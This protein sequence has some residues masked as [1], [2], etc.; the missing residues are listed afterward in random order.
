MVQQI[1][2]RSRF[3]ISVRR[4]RKESEVVDLVGEN[5]CDTRNQEYRNG[6]EDHREYDMEKFLQRTR[7]VKLCRFD[8]FRG[9]RRHFVGIHKYRRTK[10][11]EDVVY[12]HRCKTVI[13]R[14][15]ERKRRRGYKP[16][17][18]RKLK[19]YVVYKQSV[20]GNEY[21]TRN[22]GRNEKHNAEEARHR[23]FLENIVREEQP[24]RY[25]NHKGNSVRLQGYH[26][27]IRYVCAVGRV[28]EIQP[29][30]EVVKAPRIVCLAQTEILKCQKDRVEV[31]ADIKDAKLQHRPSNHNA[32][33][34]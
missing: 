24:Q 13:C 1:P 33:K 19:H 10:A 4:R 15:Q 17:L 3:V 14:I 8:N 2:Y 28:G 7:T 23:Q 32:V 12:H 26:Q 34:G 6:R 21:D 31:Y 11:N 30:L 5:T 9:N 27:R 22:D 29:Q 18:F 25:T 16:P 20:H